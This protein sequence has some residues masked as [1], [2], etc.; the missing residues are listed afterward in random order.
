MVIVTY[1]EFGG[2]WDHVSPPGQGNDDGPHDVWGPGTRIPALVLAP[3]L[4]GQFVVD[5]NE[6]DTSS[7]MATI[8][9][10]YDLAQSRRATRRSTTSPR[11]STPRSRSPERTDPDDRPP[12]LTGGRIRREPLASRGALRRPGASRASIEA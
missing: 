8:E 9:H 10:R 5:S 6:H 11:C 4:K 12:A 7:I 2:Q 1:D 3:H